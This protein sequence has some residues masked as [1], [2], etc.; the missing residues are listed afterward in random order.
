MYGGFTLFKTSIISVDANA[1]PKRNAAKPHALLK[2]CKIIKLGYSCNSCVKDF[3]LEKLMYASSIIT[4]PEKLFNTVSISALL[5]ELPVG[6]LG[7]QIHISFVFSSIKFSK[8]TKS[9]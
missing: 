8:C 2:V 4:K 7:E 6:L 9:N 1:I 5:I 3:C